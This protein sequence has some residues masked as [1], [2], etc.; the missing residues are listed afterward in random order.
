MTRRVL[1]REKP[2]S[3]LPS[4]RAG[5]PL[6]A[7]CGTSSPSRYGTSS[8]SRYSCIMVRPCERRVRAVQGFAH[9]TVWGTNREKRGRRHENSCARG[10]TH[11]GRPPERWKAMGPPS[12]ACRG[13]SHRDLVE[14]RSGRFSERGDSGCWWWYLDSRRRRD[15]AR[16]NTFVHNLATSFGQLEAIHSR[17]GQP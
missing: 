4:H 3:F 14:L 1:S 7:M 12:N 11:K 15:R 8:Q 17:L 16:V 6:L 10:L 5:A 9:M 2:F 13:R